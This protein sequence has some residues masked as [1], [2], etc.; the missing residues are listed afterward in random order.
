M[1]SP[2]R[3][4][5]YK[6]NFTEPTDLSL[7]FFGYLIEM[8]SEIGGILSVMNGDRLCDRFFLG[9]KLKVFRR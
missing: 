8:M 3:D 5:G 6:R 2:L 9:R 1:H 7:P 4:I